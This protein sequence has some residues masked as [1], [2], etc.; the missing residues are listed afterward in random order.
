MRKNVDKKITLQRF[1]R[2]VFFSHLD[3]FKIGAVASF[4]DFAADL[5]RFERTKRHFSRRHLEH[6]KAPA[7]HVAA[8]RR[9]I[10]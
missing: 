6:H 5:W 3:V 7:P 8:K 9:P 4:P 2:T 1:V 10:D